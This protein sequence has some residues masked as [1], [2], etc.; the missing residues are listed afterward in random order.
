MSILSTRPASSKAP[1]S[2]KSG[3]SGINFLRDQ[4]QKLSHVVSHMQFP[5]KVERIATSLLR[6]P[7][8]HYN[9]RA[10]THPVREIEISV[11]NIR[12]CSDIKSLAKVVTRVPARALLAVGD[13]SRPK[14][15]V[16]AYEFLAEPSSILYYIH[17]LLH[18]YAM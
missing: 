17:F 4:S 6:E 9:R 10:R 13:V 12:Q 18:N 3:D 16:S 15:C 2:I 7:K 8:P 1:S 5:T 11:T 14:S